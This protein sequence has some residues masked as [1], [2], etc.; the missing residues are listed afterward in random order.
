VL[1]ICRKRHASVEEGRQDVREFLALAAIQTVSLAEPEA[2]AALAAFA[3]YGKGRGH[4]AHLNLGDC[5]SYAVAQTHHTSLLFKGD[6]FDK[7]DIPIAA[8]S[9]G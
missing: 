4:P 5:F 8:R 2:E 9:R 3:R 7:T 1:G 6:D